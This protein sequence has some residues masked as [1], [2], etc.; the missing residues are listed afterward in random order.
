VN[1]SYAIQ[2]DAARSLLSL[3]LKGVWSEATCDSFER[4]L[5][6]ERER[7]TKDG[8]RPDW[9]PVLVDAT[10][11]GVQPQAVAARFTTRVQLFPA[12][13]H[14]AFVV[15]PSQLKKLQLR[16]VAGVEAHQFFE[17][18]QGAVTWLFAAGDRPQSAAA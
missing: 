17:N 14:L 5:D 7:M 3:T 16:R 1:A 18:R 4:D 13:R 12:E 8:L 10:D 15:A 9:P 11:F 2:V 6:A